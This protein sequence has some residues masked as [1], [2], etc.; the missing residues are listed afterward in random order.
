MRAKC[1]FTPHSIRPRKLGSRLGAGAGRSPALLLFALVVAAV[2]FAATVFLAETHGGVVRAFSAP[3]PPYVI[4]TEAELR[5]VHH[6]R[7]MAEFADRPRFTRDMIE[8]A[9]RMLRVGTFEDG[10][11]IAVRG[12]RVQYIGG[13]LFLVPM[14]PERIQELYKD[15]CAAPTSPARRLP[16]ASAHRSHIAPSASPSTAPRPEQPP[17]LTAH[18]RRES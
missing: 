13:R 5:A 3:P 2:A 17:S 15:P 8:N 1:A 6:K 11:P 7:I 9:Y 12:L 18:T 16:I 10:S 14:P 4:T